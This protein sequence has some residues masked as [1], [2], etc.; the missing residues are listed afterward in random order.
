MMLHKNTGHKKFLFAD[1]N[2]LSLVGGVIFVGIFFGGYFRIESDW[3]QYRDDGVITMSA[4]KNW[5]EYGF[6]GVSPSGEKVEAS[7][8]PVQLFVYA[9]TYFATSIDYVWFSF[10]QTVLSTFVIGFL[11]IKFFSG[12]PMVAVGIAT[13]SAIGMTFFYPFFE[14]HASGMENA[15][16]HVLF[17]ST[18]Y[19]MYAAV[20]RNSINYWAAFIV[21]IA[22]IA[23]L[24]SVYH[25][26]VLLIIY[27]IYWFACNKN[28][29]AFGFSLI[30][31]ALWAIFQLWR[32]YYFGDILPNTAYAQSIN[33]LDRVSMLL[34]GDREY[35][36]QSLDLSKEIF[37]NQSGW[38]LVLT[39]LPLL[40]FFR[41]NKENILLLL[42]IV[43]IVL[44]SCF[45]PFLFGAARIDHARTTT[46]M[47][48]LVFLLI[49]VVF[50]F[51]RSIKG[52]SIL[53][54]LMLPFVVAFYRD[55]NIKPYYLGW[56]TDGFNSIRQELARI[57]M[58]NDIDR[59]TI[60]NPDLG[61][62]SWYK[63]FN[64]ID[65]GMLGS[66]IMAKLRNDSMVT[67]YYLGYGLPDI[68]EAHGWWIHEYCDPIFATPTFD[69][70]YSQIETDYD[71][72]QICNSADT[73]PMIYWIR[74]DI[75]RDS[76][77]AERKFLDDLQN[78]LSSERVDEEIKKCRY[79]KD[80]CS[81]IART[82]YKF[83]PEFI[84]TGQFNT[85]YNLF[86]NE[87][88][89]ALLIGWQN[90]QAHNFILYDI[91]RKLN[92]Q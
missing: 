32:Y 52:S 64:I 59:P 62:M 79:L 61:V 54:V 5:V 22:T 48:L 10:W 55:Q 56:S 68:I 78:R 81:Y 67:A 60:S 4:A 8:S 50:Y 76:D 7:S 21:F 69:R 53:F 34:S 51:S 19:V 14:W 20:K 92:S 87:T 6:I 80:D 77:S 57:A 84:E 49:A 88:D 91:Q 31:F 28:L 23:R 33:V 27:S 36:A 44:T 24:D 25:I 15:I 90:A 65:L 71:L 82:V 2:I 63:E 29:K 30:V 66:P 40:Y 37:M 13:A 47:T 3:Y 43:A 72:K 83:I 35:F 16:T 85:V 70:L 74:N 12:K 17:L 42:L 38:L 89:K 26:S 9:L 11:F 1:A 75:K 58:E 86:T 46:Q 73:P 18:L 45:S 41:P 39:V